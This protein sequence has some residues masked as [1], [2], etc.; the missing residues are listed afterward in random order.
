MASLSVDSPDYIPAHSSDVDTV[1]GIIRLR[2]KNETLT[3]VD[4]KSINNLR[5]LDYTRTPGMQIIYVQHE[6]QVAQRVQE[7]RHFIALDANGGLNGPLSSCGPVHIVGFDTETKPKYVKG[8]FSHPVALVQLATASV[9]MLFHLAAFSTDQPI[10]APLLDL[11]ADTSVLKVGVG[12]S[13][14]VKAIRTRNCQVSFSDFGRYIIII[15]PT[16]DTNHCFS[17][18][19]FW[20][21]S[22]DGRK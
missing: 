9:C 19:Y 1:A 2:S 8:A 10:P 18:C 7:L 3:D 21:F 20:L 13:A 5:Q 12:V 17:I 4:K 15:L 22:L 6:N 11:L 16:F 14:D